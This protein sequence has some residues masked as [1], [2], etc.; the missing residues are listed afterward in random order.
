SVQT[1]Q[2][3]SDGL[4]CCLGHASGFCYSISM[5]AV[6]LR[7]AGLV[8]LCLNCH[9][10][11]YVYRVVDLGV[12]PGDVGS[13]GA[14]I[15]ANG[16]ISGYSFSFPGFQR[17]AFRYSMGIMTNIGDLGGGTASAGGINSAG[18]IC[19]FSADSNFSFHAFV[20][21][22][23]QIKNLDGLS[24]P[25]DRRSF[26]TAINASGQVT[27]DASTSTYTQHA[28]LYSAGS[29]TDLGALTNF[30]LSQGLAITTAGHV[31]GTASNQTAGQQAFLYTGGALQPLPNLPG[32]S[33]SD[34]QAINDSDQI[35]GT[36]QNSAG[37]QTA[38][39]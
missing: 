12:L 34:A 1:A 30:P 37:V 23:G 9:A 11:S 18:D 15:N 8:L 2:S 3:V 27:G 10:A 13:S 16:E 25:A 20:F 29:F 7:F 5:P 33:S 32:G 17:H 35:V 38:F 21:S 24:P 39:L 28:F 6:A 36:A 31:A 4:I 14:A 26:G 19:G 22:G